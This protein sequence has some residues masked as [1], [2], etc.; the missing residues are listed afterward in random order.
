MCIDYSGNSVKV[1]GLIAVKEEDLGVLA[2]FLPMFPHF[3]EV[4]GRLAKSK[5][6]KVFSKRYAKVEK[7]IVKLVVSEDLQAV[8]DELENLKDRAGRI[9]ADV[10]VYRRIKR[11][12]GGLEVI[13]ENKKLL[14]HREPGVLTAFNILDL[15]MNRYKRKR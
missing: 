11:A 7:Y 13:T 3:S 14:K 9:Y 1:Y 8:V 12:L 2:G 15:A 6:L 10:H 4:R 5:I